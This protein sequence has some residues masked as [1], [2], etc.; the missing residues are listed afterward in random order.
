MSLLDG[1]IVETGDESLAH[2][3]EAHGYARFAESG[4]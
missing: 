4:P 3:L 1:R 2:K